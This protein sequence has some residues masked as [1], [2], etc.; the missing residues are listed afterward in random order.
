MIWV[1]RWSL[2]TAAAAAAA[3]VSQNRPVTY[4]TPI[5]VSRAPGLP[6][7]RVRTSPFHPLVRK[8]IPR[9]K[10][11]PSYCAIMQG[12]AATVEAPVYSV[13]SGDRA[14]AEQGRF[15]PINQSCP[16]LTQDPCGNNKLRR[17]L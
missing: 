16:P 1:L 5:P 3:S 10:N 9:L 7:P 15:L 4:D 2:V 12:S 14:D 6:T 17:H 11:S 8:T 13:C